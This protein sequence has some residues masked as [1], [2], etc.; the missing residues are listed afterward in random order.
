MNWKTNN[1]ILKSFLGTLFSSSGVCPSFPYI[2]SFEICEVKREILRLRCFSMTH[3]FHTLIFQSLQVINKINLLYVASKQTFYYYFYL[4]KNFE[5]L[6]FKPL[7]FQR[8]FMSLILLF[9][10]N[11]TFSSERNVFSIFRILFWVS[12]WNK[13]T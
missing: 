12:F 7:H 2:V 3:I 13:H 4:V 10:Y 11:Q 1:L 6:H 9:R 8:S 5:Q